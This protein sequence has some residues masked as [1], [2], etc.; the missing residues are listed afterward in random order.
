MTTQY[1]GSRVSLISKTDIRYEGILYSIDPTRMEVVLQNVQ[2]F[3][4]EDRPT[5]N[6]IE[7]TR[8][9]PFISFPGDDIKELNVCESP[10]PPMMPLGQD[11]GYPGPYGYPQAPYM[12]PQY[13][14]FMGYSNPYD[15]FNYYG[16]DPRA[17]PMHQFYGGYPGQMGGDPMF[18]PML[19]PDMQNNPELSQGSQDQTN[20][21]PPNLQHPQAVVATSI[22]QDQAQQAQQAQPQSNVT[23][24]AKVQKVQQAPVQPKQE[25]QV[26]V[27]K[28]EIQEKK[29]E[30]TE[31]KKQ[32]ISAA[33]VAKQ[34]D[35]KEKPEDVG[36]SNDQSNVNRSNQSRN[37]KRNQRSNRSNDKRQNQ[38]NKEKTTPESFA[39][40]FDFESSLAKFDKEKFVAEISDKDFDAEE[41]DEPVAYQKASFFDTISCEATDRDAERT[42]YRTSQKQQRKL[43]TE[44]FGESGR[45]NRGRG[46]RNNRGG[47][48]GQRG[49]YRKRKNND[50]G[51]TEKTSTTGTA[52]S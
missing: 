44:T 21:Q 9:F 5:E 34:A 51:N 24:Q 26:P 33:P 16:Y 25:E 3:G 30:K 38:R 43:D 6:P 41:F 8:F 35:P 40:D 19:H 52:G 17:D 31:E 39:E 27:P 37:K 15:Q 46:R 14:Q 47:R 22:P 42:D 50:S 20:Q 28:Q 10:E 4:T 13:G 1:I 49:Y 2:S 12:H 32:E 7:A 48:R 29:I 45:S 36:A 11:M 18:N 23:K